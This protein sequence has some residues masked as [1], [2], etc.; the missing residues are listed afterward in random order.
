MTP[1][2]DCTGCPTWRYEVSEDYPEGRWKCQTF[3]VPLLDADGH[4]RAH[5]RRMHR[6]ESA[7]HAAKCARWLGPEDGAYCYECAP[8]IAAEQAERGMIARLAVEMSVS[9]LVGV[10]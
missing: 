9:D 5:G 7:T 1:T 8:I 6:C 2:P 3:D 4:C 10:L